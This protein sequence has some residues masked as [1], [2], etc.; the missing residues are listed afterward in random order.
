MAMV[1]HLIAPAAAP[2][3]FGLDHEFTVD[4]PEFVATIAGAS[5]SPFLPG[6][7]VELLDNGDAFYPPMLVTTAF[8]SSAGCSPRASRSRNSTGPC[9]ITRP[10]SSTAAG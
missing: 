2:P 8:G 3:R 4:S 7:A 9:S 10:W 1:S 6:N 5:G